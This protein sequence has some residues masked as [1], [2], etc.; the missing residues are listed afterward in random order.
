LFV[1]RCRWA[2]SARARF[3]SAAGGEAVAR[4]IEGPVEQQYY[5][6]ASGAEVEGGG[7]KIEGWNR[8]DRKQ[9]VAGVL[10]AHLF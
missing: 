2:A 3:R 5:E 4:A 6:G 10:A 8:P 7:R 9:D 1:W